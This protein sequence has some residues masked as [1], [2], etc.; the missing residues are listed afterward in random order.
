MRQQYTVC[1]G[2]GVGVGV[3]VYRYL[4]SQSWL[5]ALTH[6]LQVQHL[7]LAPFQIADVLWA[8]AELRV[9][10]P[11]SLTHK[12]INGIT[13]QI[14]LLPARTLAVALYA[15][16]RLRAQVPQPLI[17]LILAEVQYEIDSMSLDTLAGIAWALAALKY[18]PSGQLLGRID[19]AALGHVRGML[20]AGG[21]KGSDG[22]VVRGASGGSLVG[23]KEEASAGTRATLQATTQMEA[24]CRLVAAR[25]YLG[26]PPPPAALGEALLALLSRPEV[27]A[28][29][30][31]P[32]LL[33]VVR[34]LASMGHVG[35]SGELLERL[36]PAAMQSRTTLF[37]G[38]AAS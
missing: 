38:P 19:Q 4:P 21:G 7:K 3:G 29:V 10:L 14:A 20:G 32:Q 11:T 27:L 30:T 33:L 13:D 24:L 36:M 23:D 34:G 1:V 9:P 18:R 16:A 17:E 25:G 31:A 37:T 35:T 28:A 22:V 8:V 12:L 2:V 6:S 15:L 5:R 26:G